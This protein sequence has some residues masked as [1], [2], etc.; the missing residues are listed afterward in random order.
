M[1]DVSSLRIFSNAHAV[2]GKNCQPIRE[3]NADDGAKLLGRLRL[4]LELSL[5]GLVAVA[6]VLLLVVLVARG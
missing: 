6:G 1:F 2:K 4:L 3:V 5:R